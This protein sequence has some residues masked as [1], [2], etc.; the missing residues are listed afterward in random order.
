MD[1]TAFHVSPAGNDAWSGKWAEPLHG[2]RSEGPFG[3]LETVLDTWAGIMEAQRYALRDGPFATLARALEATRALPPEQPRRI[4]I[5]EGAYYGVVCML[6]ARDNGLTLEAAPDERPVLYGGLP[7]DN[8]LPDPADERFVCADVSTLGAQAAEIRALQVNGRFCPRARLPGVGAF[9]HH[10]CFNVRWMS[11]TLGGWERK[12]THEELTT[13]VFDPADLG[14]WLDTRNAELTVYHAWDDSTV[15]I[16]SIDFDTHTIRF[17]N[18]AGH[19]AGAF[20]E[21]TPHAR[22]YV[23]WNVQEGMLAPGQWYLDRTHQR[24]VYWPLAG[25]SVKEAIAALQ[26]CVI[27]LDGRAGGPIRTVTIRGLTLSGT[28]TPLIAADF[29]AEKLAGALD[30]EGPIQDCLFEHLTIGNVAGH[31]IKLRGKGNCNLRVQACHIDTTGAGGIYL[32]GEDCRVTHN[33]VSHTGLMYPAAIGIFFDGQRNE[34]SHNDIH[35]TSYSGIDSGG[36]AGHRIEHNRFER[37]MCVLNDGAAIY[38][39]ANRGTIIRGNVATNIGGGPGARHAYYLDERSEDCLVAANLAVDVP[40]SLHNHMAHHNAIRDNVC[41][42]HGDMKVSFHRS[43][44]YCLERNIF[45]ATGAIRF[46]GV[47]GVARFRQNIFYSA[48]G[49]VEGIHLQDYTE[50][51]DPVAFTSDGDTCLADPCFVD[52]A[53]GDLRLRPESPAYL[54]GIPALVVGETVSHKGVD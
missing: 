43:D 2:R 33:S 49:R 3:T 1:N 54:L 38:A 26:T 21:G 9:T 28:T 34:V 51:G 37:V 20:G 12:P 44:D 40:W 52:V 35:D 6:D 31:G 10:S 19:P 48:A 4:V 45:Y 32:S 11:A 53:Q 47:E 8:W 24:I 25:E 27:R 17:S 36:G 14:P 22:T 15:G 50:V 30:G 42:V 29:G 16:Q 39:F 5:H 23:V 46:I 18:P 13:L 7:L 41:I